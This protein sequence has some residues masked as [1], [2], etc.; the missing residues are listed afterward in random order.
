MKNK[1]PFSHAA[2][3][4]VDSI[5]LDRDKIKSFIIPAVEDAPIADP[6]KKGQPAKKKEEKVTLK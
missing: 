5:T 3:M 1:Y 4:N 6:A 2:N